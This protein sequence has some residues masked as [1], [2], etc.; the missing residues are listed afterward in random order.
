MLSNHNNEGGKM[1]TI[2]YAIKFIQG[3]AKEL[4]F[5]RMLVEEGITFKYRQNGGKWVHSWGELPVPTQQANLD[6]CG[7]L[8]ANRKL[9]D[10]ED[11][12]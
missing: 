4:S 9:A 6:E 3:G 10:R 5:I 1:N 12:L 2:E 8:R 7:R 11:D